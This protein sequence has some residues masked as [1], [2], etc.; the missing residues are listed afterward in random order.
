MRNR[1]LLRHVR[2]GFGGVARFPA[3][4]LSPAEIARRRR[5]FAECDAAYA[6]M[7]S[8]PALWQ[9]ELAERRLWE[10]TLLDGLEED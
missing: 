3:R 7:Q 6:E 2:S 9:Q 1:R 4:K 10:A 8:D 5:F